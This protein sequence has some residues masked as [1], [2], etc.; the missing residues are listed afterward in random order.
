MHPNGLLRGDSSRASTFTI[1][2]RWPSATPRPRRPLH[3]PR[4]SFKVRNVIDARF[5][6]ENGPIVQH[7]DHITSNA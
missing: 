6:L 3:V 7:D 2:R 1:I 5:R 4:D